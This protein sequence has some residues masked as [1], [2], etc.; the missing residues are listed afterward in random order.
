MSDTPRL[1]SLYETL[2]ACDDV[3]DVLPVIGENI[4]ELLFAYTSRLLVRVRNYTSPGATFLFGV[5]KTP[6]KAEKGWELCGIND[7]ARIRAAV[8][9]FARRAIVNAF[10]DPINLDYQITTGEVDGFRLLAAHFHAIRDLSVHKPQENLYAYRKPGALL[11]RGEFEQSEERASHVLRNAVDDYRRRRQ[12]VHP[13]ARE[14]RLPDEALLRAIGVTNNG[15]FSYTG[16][17]LFSYRKTRITLAK[18][19]G[20]DILESAVQSSNASGTRTTTKLAGLEVTVIGDPLLAVLDRI[21]DLLWDELFEGGKYSTLTSALGPAQKKALHSVVYEAILNAVAHSDYTHDYTRDRD[22]NHYFSAPAIRVLLFDNRVEVRSFG[23]S[24]KDPDTF[25]NQSSIAR[26]P[27]LVSVLK[28]VNELDAKGRGIQRM[29]RLCSELGMPHPH[30]VIDAWSFTATLFL[31]PLLN[32]KSLEESFADD[33]GEVDKYLVLQFL[34]GAG[35]SSARSAAEYMCFCPF[36]VGAVLKQLRLAQLVSFEKRPVHSESYSDD[37]GGATYAITPCGR[38]TLRERSA[39]ED[40]ELPLRGLPE[41]VFVLKS[42]TSLHPGALLV[43]GKTALQDTVRHKLRKLGI[44][45]E[46]DVS[47]F[48][49]AGRPDPKGVQPVLMTLEFGN[50]GGV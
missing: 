43:S 50:E 35:P 23:R 24:L 10:L 40:V 8:D 20:N 17:A 25:G 13:A 9:E 47:A 49:K 30:F 33:P 45:S 41:G 32:L 42:R 38:S 46:S 7:E 48:C 36:Y 18:I 12:Q 44:Y 3:H 28:D 1:K 34:A 16:A 2:V 39:C 14:L 37:D 21:R 11:A 27:I 6:S 22:D 31:R 26:N 5:K 19:T 4:P 15:V 29:R